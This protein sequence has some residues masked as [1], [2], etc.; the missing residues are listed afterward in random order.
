[1]A[2]QDD[3]GFVEAGQRQADTGTLLDTIDLDDLRL[4]GNKSYIKVVAECKALH[5]ELLENEGEGKLGKYI[6]NPA[7]IGNY[8]GK[9]RLN[10]NMLFQYSNIY[11]D[12]LSDL[13]REYAG[14]RQS[15]YTAQLQAGKSP[16]AAE[17]HARE[18]SRV[19]ETTIGVI[20]NTIQQIKNEYERFNGI[21]MYLQSRMKEFNT[22]RVMG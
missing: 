17:K 9:L 7:L 11:I 20:E 19:D 22:E 5:R 12:I 2:T 21:C 14:K 15:L 16:S 10:A 13:Q 4:V 1:M 8:L 6:E 18:M 3:D